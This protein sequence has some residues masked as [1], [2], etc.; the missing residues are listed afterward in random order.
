MD[1]TLPYARYSLA[2]Y[3]KVEVAA[4]GQIRDSRDLLYIC[5]RV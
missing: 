2:R 3:S 1:D 4:T 5:F